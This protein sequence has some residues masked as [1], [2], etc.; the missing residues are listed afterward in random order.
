MVGGFSEC[1][2]HVVQDAIRKAFPECRV[3]IPHQAGLAVQIGAVLFGHSLISII[4][5]DDNTPV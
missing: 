4:S 1:K 5:D 2:I 3:V